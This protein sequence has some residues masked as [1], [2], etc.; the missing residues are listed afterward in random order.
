MEEIIPECPGYYSRIFLVPK[1][2]GKLRLIIDLSVLNHFIFTQTFK[3]ETQRKVKDA[4]QLNNWAFSL[5]LTDAYLH[6]PIHPQSRKYLRFTLGGRV[7]Q[8]KALPFGLSTSP[9]VFTHLMKVIATFLRRMAI[10]LHP[11]LDDWLSRNQSRRRLLE[12]RQFILS[13]INSLGLIMNYE[14]SDL[15]PAQVFTFIGMEFLTHTNIVRV[16]QTRQMKILETVRM[17]SQKT[18]VSARDFLSLLGQHSECC[19]RLCNAGTVTSPAI[20]NVSAQSVATAETSFV[21][22]DSYDNGNSAT[23]QMVAS[24]RSLSS[25][26][27][28]EDRSSLPHHI[29]RRQP[30]GLGS[31]CGTGG[32]SVSWSMDRRPIPAPHQCAVDESNSSLSITSCSQGK[33]LHCVGVNGQHHSGSLHKASGRD[34]FHRTHRR[35]VERPELV[36]SPQHTSVSEAHTE[37]VQHSSRPDVPSRQTDLHRVVPESGNSKQDFPDHGLSINRPVRHT[38][39]PQAAN[40]CVTH[41]GSEGAINRC[42]LDGLE[43]HTRL[44]VS[45]VPSYS[46][47]DKQ[48]TVIPVQDS[49]D[50]TSMARQ[51]MV[52]RA[53]RSVGVTTGISTSNSKPASSAKRQ[54]SASKPGPSST[55][56]LG[57]VKQSLRDKQFSSEVAEHVSKARRVSTAEVYDAKWQIFH[58]WANQ[59][60]IDPIEATPQ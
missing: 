5:D 26:D 35:S 46:S 28:S 48:N 2:N 54:N 14:K 56:R 9:F 17:V 39:E 19:S 1:K 51:T 29:Y 57:I 59:R 53:H 34:S 38:S 45:T 47:C 37:Q 12:H 42:P 16:P 21:S 20:T 43:S 41:T 24:G 22:S 3:M 32:T 4:I 15:V 13:L 60:K 58:D 55:S 40:I 36:L 27:S 6:V 49:I 8:F 10:T 25:G 23:S 11:Y 7:Y 31:S 52:F 50:S 18:S 44:R 33:E 30:V